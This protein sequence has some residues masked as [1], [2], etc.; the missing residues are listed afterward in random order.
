VWACYLIGSEF[1]LVT[2]HIPHKM[3]FGNMRAK[4]PV[5]IERWGLRLMAFKFRVLHV[6]GESNMNR[7]YLSRHRIRSTNDDRIS[8]ITEEYV[9]NVINHAT[10]R[11][12]TVVSTVRRL[13]LCS[14]GSFF[15]PAR[16]SP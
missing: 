2:D 13:I 11:A 14:V 9:D 7:D 6:R 12:Q 3:I 4:S 15:V 16:M 10:L 8:R 1:D 5:R